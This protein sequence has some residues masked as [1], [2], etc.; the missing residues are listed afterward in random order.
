MTDGDG[1]LGPAV[2]INGADEVPVEVTLAG[3]FDPIS[4]HYRWYGR[5]ASSDEVAAL[6]SEGVRSV[7]LRTPHREVT[8]V[9]AD[10]DPWGRPRVGGVGAAPFEV[11]TTL[12]GEGS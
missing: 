7:V 10:I 5:I 8:T 11:R 6:L 12:F 4:G 1:Y 9:L 2:L 3:Q